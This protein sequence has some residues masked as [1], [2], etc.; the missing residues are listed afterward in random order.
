MLTTVLQD[1]ENLYF[2][3]YI[4]SSCSTTDALVILYCT[5]VQ[6]KLEFSSVAWSAVTLILL[7]SNEFKENLLVYATT[8]FLSILASV[9]AMIFALR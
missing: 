7:K 6:Q 8:K 9:N 2:I 1:F 4:M 5:I 3:R